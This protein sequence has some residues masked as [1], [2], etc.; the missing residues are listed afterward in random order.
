MAITEE[1]AVQPP[2]GNW[3]WTLASGFFTILLAAAALMLP[4][5]ESAP[6]GELV[7]WLLVLAGL[8]EFTFGWK[9]GRDAVGKAAMGSGLVT[10]LAGL[11][12]VANLLSGYFPVANVIVA[13]LLLRGCWMLVIWRHARSH[14][15]G[16]W[17]ALSGAADLLLGFVLIFA[18]QVSA[19]VVTLFGPTPE[20]VAKFALILAASLLATAVSQIAIALIQRRRSLAG[21]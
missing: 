19:L 6:R 15:L 9:R 20:V 10:G 21:R 11:L 18:L 14:R 3:R 2:S 5:L 7:G 4:L 1:D 16:H 17:L 12:F 8:S 13:W